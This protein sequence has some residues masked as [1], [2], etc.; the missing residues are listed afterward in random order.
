MEVI[1]ILKNET[2]S[3]SWRHAG[4]IVANM[5]QVGDYIDWYCSGI[6]NVGNGD[7]P[8]ADDP[9]F[10][11]KGSVPEGFITEEIRNDLKKLGWIPVDTDQT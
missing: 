2:W 4:G 7:D 10:E 8:Y 6:K 11:T 5:I 1:P 3:C 9:N